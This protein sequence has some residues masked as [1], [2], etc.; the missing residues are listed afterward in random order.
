MTLTCDLHPD[1][2]GQG[3]TADPANCKRVRDLRGGVNKR[4]DDP[5]NLPRH[6]VA[7]YTLTLKGLSNDQLFETWHH[8]YDAGHTEHVKL[9]ITEMNERNLDSEAIK[10]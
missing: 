6:E 4:P 1:C 9:I 5:P 3:C 7:A 10:L 8:E 2:Q